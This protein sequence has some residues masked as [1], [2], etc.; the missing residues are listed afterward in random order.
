[1]ILALNHSVVTL[2]QL[3][4][5]VELLGYYDG[6]VIVRTVERI[7]EN[8]Q[9]CWYACDLR[10]GQVADITHQ[11]TIMCQIDQHDAKFKIGRRHMVVGGKDIVPMAMM[12][13]DASMELTFD[14]I[15]NGYSA[16]WLLP[17]SVPSSITISLLTALLEGRV[18]GDDIWK[19]LRS[20]GIDLNRIFPN[21]VKLTHNYLGG[22]DVDGEDCSDIADFVNTLNTLT[23][24]GC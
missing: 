1:M 5:P 7:A 2:P 6:V 19:G 17:D 23:T 9:Q 15:L 11:E 16:D 18:S 12:D 3:R 8:D 13:E 4:K 20:S 10:S 24:V 22:W 21:G 14:E